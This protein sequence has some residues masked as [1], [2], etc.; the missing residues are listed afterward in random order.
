MKSRRLAGTSFH[1]RGQAGMLTVGAY[2]Y[3]ALA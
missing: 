2:I 1:V 3:V